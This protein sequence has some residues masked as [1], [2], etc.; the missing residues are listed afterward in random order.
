MV[1][2]GAHCSTDMKL[3]PPVRSYKLHHIGQAPVSPDFM[4][5]FFSGSKQ[6]DMVHSNKVLTVRT[7]R[8]PNAE[9]ADC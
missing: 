1:N 8:M 4:T 2:S 5:I 6:S 7:T 3:L 9:R